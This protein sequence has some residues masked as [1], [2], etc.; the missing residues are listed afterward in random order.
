MGRIDRGTLRVSTT[1]PGLA[2]VG[3]E[4]QRSF[5]SATLR[6]V[7]RDVAYV[8]NALHRTVRSAAAAAAVR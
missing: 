4:H 3:L 6:G 1:M 5:A 7:G 8:L 2:Y